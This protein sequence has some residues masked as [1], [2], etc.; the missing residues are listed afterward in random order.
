VLYDDDR[1]HGRRSPEQDH[2]RSRSTDHEGLEEG[3][4]KEWSPLWSSGRWP[5]A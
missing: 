2:D 3:R 1:G 4:A 5:L